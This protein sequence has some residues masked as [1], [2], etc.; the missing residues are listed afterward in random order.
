MTTIGQ[1]RHN[2]KRDRRSPT[3]RRKELVVFATR[4]TA[5][6]RKLIVAAAR[7]SGRSISEETRL[8]LEQS[9]KAEEDVLCCNCG[10]EH[11]VDQDCPT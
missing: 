3:R 2:G 10:G 5:E 9:F 7:A 6:T 11:P 4:I 8:R 1:G